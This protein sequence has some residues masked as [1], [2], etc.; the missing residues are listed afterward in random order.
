MQSYLQ[1]RRL[2]HAVRKE[3]ENPS[4]E[5][6]ASPVD[7]ASPVQEKDVEAG[8][9]SENPEQITSKLRSSHP[10]PLAQSRSHRSEKTAMAY[11]LG[12]IDV[13][14]H[15]DA[16]GKQSQVFLVSWD[17]ED[18]PQNPR[19]YPYWTRVRATLLVAALGWVVTA[20][21]SI[22]TAV[23]PQAAS[24]YG[25]SEVVGSLLTGKICP[26][27]SLQGRVVS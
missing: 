5:N 1:Y 11:T 17:G 23:E 15:A 25:V 13:Q 14:K 3:L 19:N 6:G 18:D 2:G 10:S 9:I 20:S 7:Q 24:E 21:S 26:I 16:N 12:G 22:N 8:A 4:G 27:S